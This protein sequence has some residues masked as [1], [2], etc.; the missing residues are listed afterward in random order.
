MRAI[1]FA[2]LLLILGDSSVL[3]EQPLKVTFSDLVQHPDRYNG[4]TI[5]IVGQVDNCFGFGC[6]LC[7]SDMKVFG[8]G[9][10]GLEFSG[11]T[12]DMAGRR[13]SQLMERTFRFATVELEAV[14][15]PACLESYQKMLE[16]KN[17]D[18]VVVCTDRAT[19]LKDARVIE[20]RARK[21]ALDGLVSGY[22][23]GK[24]VPAP[25]GDATP[26]LAEIS[27][28]RGSN[29]N[30]QF[31]AFLIADGSLEDQRRTLG[32]A[33]VCAEETCDRRWPTR[34]FGGFESPAN[35][36]VCSFMEKVGGSWRTSPEKS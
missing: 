22:N 12:Q 2:V 4:K 36:F 30:G 9:C 11:F 5:R 18:R 25:D 20:V 13:T 32:V 21:S 15:D 19:V 28:W 31:K 8:S 27:S 6:N 23:F 35:P 10:L 1:W 34:W 26:M 17:P 33:C 7:P 3:A 24:I 14:F 16:A 29:P